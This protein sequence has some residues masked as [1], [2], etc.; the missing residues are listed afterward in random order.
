MVASLYHL[1]DTQFEASL[2][3]SCLAMPK[4]N[5]A[6]RTCSPSAIKHAITAFD[7][8]VRETS[9]DLAGGPLSN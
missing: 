2:F 7:D 8:L 9:A 1:Q 3:R 5:F 6:L 4:F